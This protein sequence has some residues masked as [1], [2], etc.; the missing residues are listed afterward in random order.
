MN[1]N[2]T[3]L[4]ALGLVGCISQSGFGMKRKNPF[5]DRR[6]LKRRKIMN[7]SSIMESSP[8]SSAHDHRRPKIIEPVRVKISHSVLV[9]SKKRDQLH[10]TLVDDSYKILDFSSYAA[11]GSRQRI[12]EK[13]FFSLIRK[14]NNLAGLYLSDCQN[15]KPATFR[16]IFLEI[17]EPKHFV[18]LSLSPGNVI[19]QNLLTLIISKLRNLKSIQI[20]NKN[21]IN[22]Y[23]L[24]AI[25]NSCK[26]IETVQLRDCACATNNGINWIMRNCSNLRNLLIINGLQLTNDAFPSATCTRL[27]S[28][29]LYDCPHIDDKGVEKIIQKNKN[30][31]FLTI[32]WC[33]KITDQTVFTIRSN[34]KNLFSLDLTKTSI[35]DRALYW[36]CK[37]YTKLRILAVNRCPNITRCGIIFAVD[38]L[39]KLKGIYATNCPNITNC[40]EIRELF[41]RN[42][43]PIIVLFDH[44]DEDSNCQQGRNHPS[45]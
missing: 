16:K 3:L 18:S 8:H 19:N 25:A 15:I 12:S 20:Q 6:N 34:L 14:C 41:S 17:I 26:K 11:W 44:E 1:I 32:S 29:S 30:I 33:P 35:T 24:F 31:T 10:Q 37:T 13:T 9:S 4:F 5:P 40:P 22:N 38:N 27:E 2:K 36:I 42:N 23:V 7:R 45:Y 21:Q 39:P 28:F 43:R